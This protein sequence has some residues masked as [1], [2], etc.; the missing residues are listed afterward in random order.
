MMQQFA[1]QFLKQNTIARLCSNK[2]VQNRKGTGA[3]H[4]DH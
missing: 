3:E 4:W 2:S 1:L